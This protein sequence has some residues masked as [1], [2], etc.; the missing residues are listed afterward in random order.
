MTFRLSS[1]LRWTSTILIAAL[2]IFSA[3]MK[4]VPVAPGSPAEDMGRTLGTTG[5]EFPL[6]VL[7]LMIVILFLVPR[8]STIGFVL[9]VGYFGGILA[10][11]LT[12]GQDATPVYVFF[13]ILTISG[14]FRNPELLSRYRNQQA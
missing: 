7:E 12:H 10:T 2:M 13:V 11:L 6:G 1:F 3:I 5:L 8:T 14:Y 4:F 9:M